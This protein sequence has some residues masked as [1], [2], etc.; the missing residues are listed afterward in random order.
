MRDDKNL[1]G[2]RYDRCRQPCIVTVPARDEVDCIRSCLEALDGQVGAQIDD[3]VVLANNCK[4][5]TAA[6]ARAVPLRPGTNL[7]VIERELV[8]AD[9][10]AGTAR[11]LAFDVAVQLAGRDGI[12]LTTDADGLVEPDWLAA[13]LDAIAAGADAVAGWV[14][15]HPLDWGKIPCELHEDDAREREYDAL[16]DRIHALLDPDPFDPEPRH[17]QHSGA[18]IAVTVGAYRRSGGIPH[19]ASGEDRAL[20]AALRRV[21]ARIRH[22]LAVHVTVSGRT[23]GRAAGGMAETISRRLKKPDEYLDDRLEPAMVCARRAAARGMLR[24]AS[25]SPEHGFTDVS[26]LLGLPV[27]EVASMVKSQCFGEAW[28]ILEETAPL[29][30][31]HRVAVAGLQDEVNAAQAILHVLNREAGPRSETEIMRVLGCSRE[32]YAATGLHDH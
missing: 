18:S 9:A 20:I 29:L 13:N 27:T 19:V 1:F 3:I 12:L 7:H 31:R 14:E 25:V 15:L 28:H 23:L 11:R 17:T 26:E 8:P 2:E 32:E 6:V 30:T 22:S 24:R 16:C 10:N 4:D 5:G 21:D